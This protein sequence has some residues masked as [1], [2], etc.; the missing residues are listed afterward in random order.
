MGGES[1]ERGIS[2]ETG[3]A[4]CAALRRCGVD[5]HPVDARGDFLSRISGDRFDRV[6][7]A[8]H[9]R[10]GED[11][12]IQGALQT[13]GIPYTGSGVLGSALAMDKVRAKWIWL[14]HDI[15]TPP[16][17][18]IFT[19]GDLREAGREIGFPLMV[20]PVHEG[21]SCG[22]SKVKG[23]E[24]LPAA[25]SK[26]RALDARVMAEKWIEGAE[27]TASILD[28]AVLPLIRLETPREFYDYEA[29]YIE[30]TTRYICPC[31]LDP[32]TEQALAAVA[33]RAFQLLGASGWG[34]VDLIVDAA[35]QPWLLEVNTIPGMTSHSL[36][37]MAAKQAGISFDEL[38]IR[39]LE[40]SM[41]A[42]A[43]AQGVAA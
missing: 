10:G 6:F 32:G 14:A 13:L 41:R 27:Y 35:G 34:R 9:G 25:W 7:L 43:R 30:N 18:E 20:K 17:V 12:E 42:Q 5:V 16:D 21:S 31:G 11:G 4:V 39:I 29:K 8:L 1:A 19:E 22:A 24:E 28:D 36:V 38:V 2:L 15:P 40:T 33:L 3:N 26:A 37:P 23:K